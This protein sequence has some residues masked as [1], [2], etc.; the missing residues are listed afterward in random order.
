MV[1]GFAPGGAGVRHGLNLPR[2][3]SKKVPM[4][5]APTSCHCRALPVAIILAALA[6]EAAAQSRGGVAPPSP[7][8]ALQ[9]PSQ[10]STA[11]NVPIPPMPIPN[12]PGASI[13]N[14]D[15]TIPPTTAPLVLPSNPRPPL[16]QMRPGEAVLALSA[17]FRPDGRAITGGLHWRVY[18]DRPD[19]SGAF[20]LVKEDRSPHPVLTLPPGGY[21]VHVAFGLASAVRPV[22]LRAEPAEAVFDIPAGGLTLKGQVGDVRIPSSQI[23][24]DIFPGSQFEPGEKR[25]IASGVATGDVVLIPEGTY[26]IL[27]KYGDGNSVVR[28]DIRVQAG[29]LTD[30]TVTHRAAAI[31]L[32]LVPNKGGEALANTDWAVMSPGGDV[33]SESKGAFPRV[34]LAEGEYKIIARNDNKTYQ[35]DLKVI[36][37]VDGEIEVLAR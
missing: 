22:Q 5:W 3:R 27:S 17:R 10:S 7:V 11:Q 24:F 2:F 16:P 20:R 8:Q 36:T 28:S 13:L 30:V 19:P 4:S 37:G 32:K 33:I 35:Q 1:P 21:V 14:P 23:A 34:I 26:Y 29:K 12:V 25:P 18:A 15:A 6:Q 31:M 9:A